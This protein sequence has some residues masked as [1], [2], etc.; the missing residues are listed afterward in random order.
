MKRLL[1]IATALAIL[2]PG[3]CL[4]GETISPMQRLAA[5]TTNIHSQKQVTPR[6]K[7]QIACAG[8]YVRCGNPG[9][10]RCCSGLSC[11]SA[12]GTASQCR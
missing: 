5:L 6:P 11:Q 10:E 8:Q 7:I 12:T 3:L 2:S 1:A 4:A 9:D